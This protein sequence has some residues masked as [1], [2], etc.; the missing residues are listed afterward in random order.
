MW[1]Y[2]L[3]LPPVGRFSLKKKKRSRNFSKKKKNLFIPGK[4]ICFS[5]VFLVLWSFCTDIYASVLWSPFND[6]TRP[7]G[8]HFH[9]T[10]ELERS[11]CWTSV[12]PWTRNMGCNRN[13]GL[14]AGAV[15]GAVLAVFGGI[16]MPV[17]DMLI[18]KTI[19]KVQVVSRIFLFILIQ[20][21]LICVWLRVPVLYFIITSNF[22]SNT[23]V[24]LNNWN[25]TW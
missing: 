20:S 22:V 4:M 6:R 18:E 15:I 12:F 10:R 14:V 24:I 13:C 7:L 2:L 11:R 5:C 21:T 3:F 9:Q 17:G 25:S 1:W 23:K 19:K 8:N 16:L